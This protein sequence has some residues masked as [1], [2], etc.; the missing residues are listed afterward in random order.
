[1][2]YSKICSLVAKASLLLEKWL[3]LQVPALQSTVFPSKSCAYTVNYDLI[4]TFR[5]ACIG[6]RLPAVCQRWKPS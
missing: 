2:D 1:M 3:E 5:A 6:Q 4:I